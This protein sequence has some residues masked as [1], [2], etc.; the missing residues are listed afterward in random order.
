MPVDALYAAGFVIISLTLY[1]LVKEVVPKVVNRNS[2]TSQ[3][4]SSQSDPS[5]GTVKIRVGDIYEAVRDSLPQMML[6][7][8]RQMEHLSNLPAMGHSLESLGRSVAEISHVLAGIRNRPCQLD[9]GSA[10]DRTMNLVMER[11]DR[12]DPSQKTRE[13]EGPN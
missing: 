8:Q 6:D 3:P 11:L 5:N 7:H 2:S 9:S 4:T 1:A 12:L 10:F 13:K